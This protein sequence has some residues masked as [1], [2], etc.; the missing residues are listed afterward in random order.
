F[1]L[2]LPDLVPGDHWLDSRVLAVILAG[3]EMTGRVLLFILVVACLLLCRRWIRLA[4]L[5]SRIYEPRREE[6][7]RFP[8]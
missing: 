4:P 1:G 8:G 5:Y 6:A 7:N 3:S 2:R